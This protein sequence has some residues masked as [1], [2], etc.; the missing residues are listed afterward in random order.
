MQEL[1]EILNDLEPD[2]SRLRDFL[3]NKAAR[4]AKG[5]QQ[6]LLAVPDM[7]FDI[8]VDLVKLSAQKELKLKQN[9]PVQRNIVADSQPQPENERT[10]TL[11]VRRSFS[12]S[13]S[14]PRK[15]YGASPFKRCTR[16]T[17]LKNM[18]MDKTPSPISF[19]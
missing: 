19:V 15:A 1:E 12:V 14:M 6:F 3:N 17:E 16:R 8:G 10:L 9:D 5:N 4:K 2:A 18:E 7:T 11:P 13:P